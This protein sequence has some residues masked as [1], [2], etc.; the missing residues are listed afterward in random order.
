[1]DMGFAGTPCGPPCAPTA[2]SYGRDPMAEDRSPPVG[3]SL[4][5]EHLTAQAGTC[6]MQSIAG[7]SCLYSNPPLLQISPGLTQGRAP[8]QGEGPAVHGHGQLSRPGL[9]PGIPRV[10]PGQAELLQGLPRSQPVQSPPLPVQEEVLDA[11]A[12]AVQDVRGHVGR[13]GHPDV[14]PVTRQ[15]VQAPRADVHAGRA[16]LATGKRAVMGLPHGP[17]PPPGSPLSLQPGHSWLLHRHSPSVGTKGLLSS[18]AEE[19]RISGSSGGLRHPTGSHLAAWSRWFLSSRR[20]PRGAAASRGHPSRRA[21][22]S[23]SPRPAAG[24]APTTAALVGCVARGPPAPGRW[25]SLRSRRW[26]ALWGTRTACQRGSS[27]TIPSPGC[28]QLPKPSLHG[29]QHQEGQG[30]SLQPCSPAHF[31]EGRR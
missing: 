30:G 15:P 12:S 29:A 16:D 9:V 19:P 10:A 1:M 31:P 14:P 25:L 24:G 2:P 17:A 20:A 22:T 26:T 8:E 5:H 4:S 13:L 18:L 21:P 23:A 11:A 6:C 28:R 27:V 3:Q 7:R